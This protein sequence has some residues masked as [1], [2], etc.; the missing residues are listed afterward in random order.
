MLSVLKSTKTLQCKDNT[1]TVEVRNIKKVILLVAHQYV[2]LL[3]SNITF[4]IFAQMLSVD[5]EWDTKPRRHTRTQGHLL[6]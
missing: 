4:L 6:W 5:G 2:N 3:L 1:G